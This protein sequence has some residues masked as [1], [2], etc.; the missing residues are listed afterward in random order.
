MKRTFWLREK[1]SPATESAAAC[2]GGVFQARIGPCVH[3]K[4]P[5][6]DLI[7]HPIVLF[8][9]ERTPP[10]QSGHRRRALR[11]WLR[12]YNHDRPHASLHYE[13]PVRLELS[14]GVRS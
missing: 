10:R 2:R 1:D 3:W 13:L 9:V 12:Y 7:R 4:Q 6:I 14:T 11:P 5:D 8:R